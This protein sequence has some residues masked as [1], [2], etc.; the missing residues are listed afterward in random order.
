M[1]ALFIFL[2]L[3]HTIK[4]A[5]RVSRVI[6]LNASADTFQPSERGTKS[7]LIR[8]FEARAHPHIHAYTS[9]KAVYVI[10]YSDVVSEYFKW[11]K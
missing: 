4:C 9:V 10:L 6:D 8:P 1:Y 5:H 11:K 3:P 2:Q 7:E